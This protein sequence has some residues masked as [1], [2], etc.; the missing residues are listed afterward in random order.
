[1][2]AGLAGYWLVGWGRFRGGY[3]ILSA[4]VT[5]A[6]FLYGLYL[7]RAWLK[8]PREPLD[9]RRLTP[10][11]LQDRPWLRSRPWRQRRIVFGAP[12][13]N[14]VLIL[15]YLFFGAPALFF[16]WVGIADP[17]SRSGRSFQAEA[18]AVGSMLLLVLVGLSYWRLRHWRHGDSVCRLL[19]LPGAVGGWLK[20]DIDC[21]LLPEPHGTVVVRLRNMILKGRRLKEIWSMEQQVA[22]PAQVGE[23]TLVK[24]RLQIPR[25]AEQQVPSVRPGN[26]EKLFGSA[27]WIL[28]LEKKVPGIDFFARFAVP[29]YDVAPHAVA[30]VASAA[31]ISGQPGQPAGRAARWSAATVTAAGALAFL[32]LTYRSYE[33][34]WLGAGILEPATGWMAR[35]RFARELDAWGSNGYYAVVIE[36]RCAQGGDE[37]RPDWKPIPTKTSFMTWYAMTPRHY[38]TRNTEYTASGYKLESTSEFTDCRG[39]TSV[40]ATWLKPN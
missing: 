30:E 39:A 28:E 38:Q 6:I 14:G 7:V 13:G 27:I 8:K 4:A 2:A 18:L 9:S 37:Y 15:A 33:A 36:G 34:G 12:I 32:A 1:M 3:A 31:P 40:Q 29:V 19:T 16:L 26:L 23:R 11:E 35:E 17:P 20:A 5:V 10:Q 24:V 22:A 25:A 21:A